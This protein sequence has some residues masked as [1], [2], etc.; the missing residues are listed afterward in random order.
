MGF[1]QPPKSGSEAGA[2]NGFRL[3]RLFLREDFGGLGLLRPR[4]AHAGGIF[5][6]I[7]RLGLL[8]PSL[9]WRLALQG[10]WG[11]GL[12]VFLWG[13]GFKK[14]WVWGFIYA[15]KQQSLTGPKSSTPPVLFVHKPGPS[16]CH[17]QKR[18]RGCTTQSR[19]SHRAP[20]TSRSRPAG[21]RHR[22]DDLAALSAGRLPSIHTSL[23]EMGF[24]KPPRTRSEAGAANGFR[25]C[26]WRFEG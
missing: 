16:R 7:R 19:S 1:F 6:S 25:L 11:Y 26:R 9:G 17:R 3:C 10:V 12:G 14:V 15:R 20:E 5:G 23:T 21:Q 13:S 22:G 8:W 4:T 2:A 18:L 24:F